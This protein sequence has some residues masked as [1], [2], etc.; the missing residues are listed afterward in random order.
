M[1]S[2]YATLARVMDGVWSTWCCRLP[3]AVDDDVH[4]RATPR[5]CPR[6]RT[7]LGLHRA[8]DVVRGPKAFWGTFSPTGD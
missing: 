3:Q 6:Q 2:I 8:T 5:V 7:H 1:Q 4:R